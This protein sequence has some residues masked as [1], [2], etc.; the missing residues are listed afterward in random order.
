MKSS[1]LSGAA[2]LVGF[3]AT[4]LRAAEAPPKEALFFPHGKVE[5]AFAMGGPLLLNS[6]YKVQTGHR[7]E[8]GQVEIHDQDT[9]IFFVTEG[10]ATLV[11]GGT[12]TGGK[13]TGPGESRGGTL[14]GGVAHQVGKGDVIIIPKGVPH[15][16]TQVPGLFLYFVVKVTESGS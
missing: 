2:L 7:V 4:G 15:Q 9:D 13:V 3:W 14:T 8:A 6:K 5:S 12:A 11:T 10:T 1:F 16:F